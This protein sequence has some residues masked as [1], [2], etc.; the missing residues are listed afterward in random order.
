MHDATPT[1]I[2]TQ[3]E[4]VE[5]TLAAVPRLTREVR[6][7]ATLN[8]IVA[9]AG[10]QEGGTVVNAFE[11]QRPI[12][13]EH[14]AAH[15]IL[16]LAYGYPLHLVEIEPNCFT[17]ST[18][19]PV[20]RDALDLTVITMAGIVVEGRYREQDLDAELLEAF[21]WVAFGEE[22]EDLGDWEIFT[23]FPNLTHRAY[24]LAHDLLD[25]LRKPHEALTAALLASTGRM[26]GNEVMALPEI[27]EMLTQEV[28]L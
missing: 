11:A 15:A 17:Q 2:R 8:H 28:Y 24:R 12:T 7:K 14:E 13:A 9:T 26:T 4:A 21:E 20:V 6:I 27:Q 22:P 10:R 23:R 19:S 25:Q 18:P 3:Q 16:Y 1:R 5:A